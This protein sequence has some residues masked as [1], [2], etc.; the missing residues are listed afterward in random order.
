MRG[1]GYMHYCCWLHQ[2]FSQFLCSLCVLLEQC[3]FNV[4]CLMPQDGYYTHTYT[5]SAHSLHYCLEQRKKDGVHSLTHTLTHNFLCLYFLIQP[6]L[7]NAR[8]ERTNENFFFFIHQKFCVVK[9][10]ELRF[11]RK[12]EKKMYYDKRKEQCKKKIEENKLNPIP[13]SRL[14]SNFCLQLE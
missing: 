14:I 2:S 3:L 12:A 5:K 13:F 9:M 1:Y 10:Y 6:F 4:A 8:N 7:S 11:K